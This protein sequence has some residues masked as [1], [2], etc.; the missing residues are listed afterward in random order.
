[1]LTITVSCRWEGRKRAFSS[2]IA[3]KAD[4][5]HENARDY[6]ETTLHQ[7][8]NIS[9]VYTS[10]RATNKQNSQ[11]A[12]RRGQYK[13]T[14]NKVHCTEM[15]G[16]NSCTRGEHTGLYNICDVGNITKR[17]YH[18]K[19]QTVNSAQNRGACL[20]GAALPSQLSPRLESGSRLSP[21][22]LKARSKLP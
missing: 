18:V 16:Q 22:L 15:E 13:E 11:S 20:E 21:R 4:L 10:P 17:I 9:C 7:V 6:T 12:A 1:M 8:V 2:R 3:W 14:L 19:C 5:L